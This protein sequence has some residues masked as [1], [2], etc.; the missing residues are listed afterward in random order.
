M[1]L[2]VKQNEAF[3]PTQIGVFGAYALV[4]GTNRFAYVFQ[5]F[6]GLSLHHRAL[7]VETLDE[8]AF[9]LYICAVQ[10]KPKRLDKGLT[11]LSG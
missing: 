6:G 2:A 11:V 8:V 5:E 4:P 3:D 9:I 7:L 10:K 1:T